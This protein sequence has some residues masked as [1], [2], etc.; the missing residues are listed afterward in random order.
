MRRQTIQASF[1]ANMTKGEE[2]VI[3]GN[4]NN[5]STPT[6]PDYVAKYAD[7]NVK[8]FFLSNRKDVQELQSPRNNQV[9]RIEQRPGLGNVYVINPSGMRR[10]VRFTLT[11][12][13]GEV[14]EINGTFSYIGEK[15]DSAAGEIG[16]ATS[17]TPIIRR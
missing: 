5:G 4:T 7:F 1:P 17:N 11:N 16:V 3:T 15:Y 12:P 6:K 2:T 14:K 9:K 10:N 8:R 13:M